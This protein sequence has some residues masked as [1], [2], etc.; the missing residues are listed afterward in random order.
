MSSGC[1]ARRACNQRLNVSISYPYAYS[2]SAA[3]VG[4]RIPQTRSKPDLILLE[5]A[6]AKP[7]IASVI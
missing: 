4:G 1:A 7:H 5:G 6:V 3:A 2:P